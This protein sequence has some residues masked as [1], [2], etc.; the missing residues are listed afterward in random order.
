VYKIAA[1]YSVML[2]VGIAVGMLLKALQYDQGFVSLLLYGVIQ[3]LAAGAFIYIL[4][5]DMLPLLQ[6]DNSQNRMLKIF[7]S[8]L[9]FI[10]ISS[11]IIVT[12]EHH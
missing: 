9:G 3:G 5:F 1:E 4:F 7:I 12:T 8:F 2:P 11:L 10:I 6:V